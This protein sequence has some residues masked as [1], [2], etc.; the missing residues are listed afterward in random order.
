[1]REIDEVA[2]SEID[3]LTELAE[4]GAF[5]NGRLSSA[6]PRMRRMWQET[7]KQGHPHT[8]ETTRLYKDKRGRLRR[9]CRICDRTARRVKRQAKAIYSAE[10]YP[11]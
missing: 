10:R 9:V 2:L 5:G 6:G 1:M 11:L 3:K 4:Q 7:C 8:P